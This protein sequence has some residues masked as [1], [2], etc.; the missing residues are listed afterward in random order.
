[1]IDWYQLPSKSIRSLILIIAMSSHP[2]K[3]SAG[4]MFDLSLATFGNVRNIYYRLFIYIKLI[5][6]LNDLNKYLTIICLNCNNLYRSKKLNT[7]N[8]YIIQP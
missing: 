1:M 8:K 2:I 4:S 6:I 5:I 7:I 3:I